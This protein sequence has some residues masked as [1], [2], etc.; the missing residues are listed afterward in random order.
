MVNKY[1]NIF[2]SC[3]HRAGTGR[4]S[5]KLQALTDVI[6]DWPA[7]TVA[8]P[9]RQPSPPLPSSLHPPPNT[10]PWQPLQQDFLQTTWAAGRTDVPASIWDRPACRAS[11]LSV[12]SVIFTPWSV[13]GFIHGLLWPSVFHRTVRCVITASDTGRQQVWRI[14]LRR[15]ESHYYAQPLVGGGIKRCCGPTSVCLTSVC[16]VHRA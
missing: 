16:R 15:I 4:T 9:T 1:E 14:A 5:H 2:H 11:T 12:R 3:V 6:Q 7:A 8:A 10:L 13:S